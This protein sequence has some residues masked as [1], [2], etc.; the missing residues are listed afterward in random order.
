MIFILR[1][2]GN[3]TLAITD[4][5][6]VTAGPGYAGSPSSSIA[7]GDL[8][9]DGNLDLVVNG[10][11]G[12]SQ[13][14]WYDV[15]IIFIGLGDGTFATGEHVRTARAACVALADLNSDGFLDLVTCNVDIS[16]L[17]IFLG[18]GDGA[19]QAGLDYP[20][21]IGPIKVVA[22]DMNGDGTADLSVADSYAGTVSVLIG[23]GDGTFEP[24]RDY[25]AGTYV[26]DV[27]S[28]DVNADGLLDLIVP[29]HYQDDVVS[30]LLGRGDGSVALG[31]AFIPGPG[32]ATVLSGDFDRNGQIDIAVASAAS[33]T[34]SIHYGNGDA[35]FG[36][37]SVYPLISRPSGVA[38][39]DLNSDGRMDFV[40]SNWDTSRVSVALGRGDGSFEA[41]RDVK[42]G[43][44]PEHL[45]IADVDSDGEPDVVCSNFLDSSISVLLGACGR[46]REIRTRLQTVVSPNGIAVGD[47]NGDSRPDIAV[48]A[49]DMSGGCFAAP[50]IDAKSVAN[51]SL[52]S[53]LLGNGDGTFCEHAETPAGRSYSAVAIGDLNGDGHQ[54]VVAAD[55]SQ[56]AGAGSVLALF[57]AGSG[58]FGPATPIAAGLNPIAL[59]L[60][61][62]NRDG[63]LDLIVG[64]SNFCEIGG[65]ISVALGRG[66]GSF[67]TMSEYSTPGDVSAL[68]IADL[69]GDGTLDVVAACPESNTASVRLGNGDGTLGTRADFGCGD[70]PISVGIGDLDGDGHPDIV[71]V[72]FDSN[73]AIILMNHAKD[74]GV[75]P[76]P[77]AGSDRRGIVVSISPN[78]FNASGVLDFAT[79]KTG[80]ARVR[81]FDARG[82]L[83]RTLVEV[84]E[85]RSGQHRYAI[86]G[87][88]DHGRNL[89]TGL[90]FYRVDAD[91]VSVTGRMALV[92]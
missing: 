2:A 33:H 70:R 30:I 23:R 27:A 78:P 79:G 90:Y 54:D 50:A 76:E 84:Q 47:L 92:K 18:R 56:R 44:G 40:A 65:S 7:T 15:V 57:G 52:L 49:G 5:L 73:D 75:E 89:A 83:V 4:S 88:D 87:R 60:V 19:F 1:G 81:I 3:G 11:D 12:S 6:G 51:S 25:P 62:L 74:P 24:K 86:D 68:A 29:D 9:G 71:A 17:T 20:T 59:S 36:T 31:G 67:G 45:L 48:V 26:T 55:W 64:N 43:L 80:P 38:L 41:R 21:G 13:T 46:T 16:T 34:V 22:S 66:D 91:G 82:R 35:T 53:I 8:N 37:R 39:A 63:A 28:A 42:V 77:H 14:G 72:N 69:D 85:L 58:T 32:Y 10:L 61:D